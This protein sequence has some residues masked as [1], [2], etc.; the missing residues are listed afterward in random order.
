M[1]FQFFKCFIPFSESGNR[2]K[3]LRDPTKKMSKS[4]PDIRGRIDLI[5]TPDVILRHIKRAVT[6]FT[7]Q[8]TFDEESRPGVSNLITIHSMLTGKS[9]EDI[10]KESENQNTGE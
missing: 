8:V 9:V 1:N 5:D 2:V 10:C 4:N 6:D 7:S 3:S